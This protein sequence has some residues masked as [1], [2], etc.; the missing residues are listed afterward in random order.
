LRGTAPGRAQGWHARA[1]SHRL[2]GDDRAAARALRRG[3]VVLDSHRASLG[4]TELR[5]HSGAYGQELAAEGLDIAVR[6][7]APARVLAWAE[8]WRA[9][10]VRTRAALPPADPDLF[11]ALTELRLVSSLLEDT[12]LA[13]RPAHALRGR[14]ARLEQHIRD[15]SRRV[16]GGG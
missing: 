8:R 6:S 4:A 16:P 7:G 12:L 15:L 14:Q 1:L 13:G 10:A 3:L 9:S 11:A 2:A 5:A